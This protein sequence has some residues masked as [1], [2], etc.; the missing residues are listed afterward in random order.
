MQNIISSAKIWLLASF[1][2]SLCI[3]VNRPKMTK[4]QFLYQL[5][6]AS[7]LAVDFARRFVKNVLPAQLEYHVKLNASLDD[8]TLVQFDVFP[9]DEGVQKL[10]LADWQVVELLCRNSKV[11]VW[12]DINVVSTKKRSTVLNLLCAGR[13]S[14]DSEEFYY[15]HSDTGPF[16][17]KSPVLPYDYKEG[18]KFLLKKKGFWSM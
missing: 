17:I 16:G 12:I 15:N 6:E 5:Q 9:E 2:H 1:Q 11:P 4:L 13:Y 3:W 14:N 7:G 8:P 10:G 18:E